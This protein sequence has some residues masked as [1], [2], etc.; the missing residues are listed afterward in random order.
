M[1]Q[2]L[3]IA[4]TAIMLTGCKK[5]IK[6]TQEQ[7]AESLILKAMTDGTWTVAVYNDGITEYKG[8]FDVYEFKFYKNK[9]VDAIRN[10]ATEITGTWQ[11]DVTNLTISSQYGP[12]ANPTLLRLNGVWK[13]KDSNWTWVKATQI[14]NGNLTTLELR[15]K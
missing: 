2:I 11:E 15:K 13:M 14:I 10:S 5:I 7:I 3:L 6:Q 4:F 9:N 8:E 12:S 1:K